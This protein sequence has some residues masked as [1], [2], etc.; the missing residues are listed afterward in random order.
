[1]VH[2][3]ATRGRQDFPVVEP[4]RSA[5]SP[6]AGQSSPGLPVVPRSEPRR[7]DTVLRGYDRAQVDAHLARL[8]EENAALRRQ[9]AEAD[10]RR[11]TAEQHASATEGEFRKLQSQRQGTV[12]EESFGFRAEKLLRLAEQEA[13]DLRG[14][15]S[16]ETAAL[17]EQARADAEKHRH[18]VEQAMISRS[19]Q[20]EE[21]ASQRTVELQE[22]ERQIAEQLAAARSEAESLHDAARRAADQHRKQAESAAETVRLRAAQ[23][24]QRLREQAQQEV[25]RLSSV[26]RDVR[27]ELGR[28]AEVLS[29]EMTEPTERTRPRE[30]PAEAPR[31]ETPRTET[32]RT[33][34]DAPERTTSTTASTTGAERREPART[35]GN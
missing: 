28:L 31:T 30:T 2:D 22:R 4:D 18:E 6:S 25:T 27:A 11:Q 15:A 26:Q 24:A 8:T 9:A 29:A 12:P 1:M 32:P 19:S 21:Q 33:E 23:D 17:L 14:S 16:R 13:N 10:R 34:A 7:F 20:L 5:E 35:A 3:M